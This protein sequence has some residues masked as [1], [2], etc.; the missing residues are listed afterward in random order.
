MSAKA[1]GTCILAVDLGGTKVA[2]AA[3]SPQGELLLRAEEPTRQDGP[4]AGIGQIVQLLREL[5]LHRTSISS[6][7]PLGVGVGIPAVLAEDDQVIWAPNLQGWRNV[8]LRP[9]LEQELGLPTVVEYDGHTAVLGEWWQGAG[10]GYRSVAMVIVGT[11]LGG[12]LILDGHLY[13]GGNQL[14]GAAG[15]F[16]LTTDTAGIS[17][18]GKALGHWESLAAG[19]G[20]ASRAQALLIAHPESS[21]YG[22]EPL[23]AKEIF[24]HA[25]AGDLFSMERV[26]ELA[27]LLGVGIANIVSLINPEIVILGGSIG[28]QGDLLVDGIR[29]VVAEWAQPVAARSVVITSSQLGKDAGLYGAAYAVLARMGLSESRDRRKVGI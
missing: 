29:T 20:F 27:R 16:V 14:A 22:Y 7:E 28:R 5:L 6:E 17:P 1:S 21:L 12:G 13:R 11:G 4:Q 23:T 19:P 24:E 10:R 15:W 9:S 3:I 18:Q 26:A 8:A 25:R 2:V